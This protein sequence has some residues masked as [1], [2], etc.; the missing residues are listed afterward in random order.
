M[1]Q[2]PQALRAL[3]E[4][5]GDPDLDLLEGTLP[6]LSCCLSATWKGSLQT[7]TTQEEGRG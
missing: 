1:R 5:T 7:V 6:D 2:S 3:R 4:D